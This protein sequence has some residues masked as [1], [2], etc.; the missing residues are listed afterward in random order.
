MSGCDRYL[1]M[2]SELVDGELTEPHKTELLEHLE[3]CPGC[4]R[5]YDAFS[6]ISLSLGETAAPEGFAADVMAAVKTQGGSGSKRTRRPGKSLVRRLALAA[7]IVLA[8]LASVRLALPSDN[9]VS[10]SSAEPQAAQ[11]GVAAAPGELG[12]R[13]LEQDAAGEQ[14]A[15]NDAEPPSE[16]ADGASP[17]LCGLPGAGGFPLDLDSVTS[18][19]VDG[20]AGRRTISDGEHILL[21]ASLLCPADGEAPQELGDAYCSLGFNF[22]GGSSTFDVYVSGGALFCRADGGEAYAAEGS[23]DQLLDALR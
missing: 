16:A 5:V 18:I 2:I 17:E 11:F 19:D 22:E 13:E 12:P 23:P 21:I 10:G 1:E 4:R 8:V 7:C 20:G 3:A 15:A 6:A 14:P 9:L